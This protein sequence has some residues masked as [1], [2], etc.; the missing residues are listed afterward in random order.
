M[1]T[2]Q[3]YKDRISIMQVALEL[4]Y[5]YDREKGRTQP[6]FVLQD[7]HGKEIDSIYIKNP[8]NPSIQGYW[9]R[10]ASGRNNTGDLIGFVKEHLQSFPETAN[11]RNEIDA[12]NKILS[13]MAGISLDTR[14]ALNRFAEVNRGWVARPFNINR[15][16]RE[17]LNDNNM[18]AAM[19]FLT[20]RKITRETADTF[21]KF[22]ELIKD[23]EGKCNFRNIG[24]PYIRPGERNIVGYEIRG[25]NGFKAK[26]EGTDSTRGC[27]M[28]YL[29]KSQYAGAISEIHIAE[30]ALDIMA[31]VQ[32]NKA[33]IKLDECIFASFGGSFSQEQM[34]GLQG[35]FPAAKPVLHFDNDLNGNIYDCRVA[36]VMNDMDIRCKVNTKT[37]D[38]CFN[39]G[40]KAFSIPL[41]KFS[42]NTFREKSGLKCD[43][44]IWK[45]PKS[46]KDWNDVL[47]IPEGIREGEKRMA[48]EDFNTKKGF[49]L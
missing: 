32:L 35:L 37:N 33:S 43:L 10:G 47:L 30:S 24:F 21:K 31:F 34:K 8:Q 7:A 1:K 36:A 20:P 19:R 2:F 28:A 6:H 4:G 14:E 40:E 39:L 15:Y 48:E 26:A 16:E 17:R 25:F 11:A 22:I 18:D 5:K 12:I 45:A 3:D 23:K 49:K 41:D 46:F 44:K 38:I 27:W 29:G 13:R 9:R 42:Y